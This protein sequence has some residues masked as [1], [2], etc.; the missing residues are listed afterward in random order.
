MHLVETAD[1]P[2][3]I[4]CAGNCPAVGGSSAPPLDDWQQY[5]SNAHR[6]TERAIHLCHV[7]GRRRARPR[8]IERSAARFFEVSALAECIG[9][10]Q[11]NEERLDAASRLQ[12]RGQGICPA[13]ATVMRVPLLFVL[14]S[15]TTADARIGETPIQFA[16]RYG[17]P[18]DTNLTAIVDKS[19]P[20]LEGA[21]HHTYEYQGWKI[22][23]AFLQ[24]DGP[25]VRMAFQKTSAAVSGIVIRED[26]LQAIASANMPAG[27][28]WKPIAYDNPNSPNKGIAKAFEGL[29][30]GAA[31]Q[32]MWQRSDGAILAVQSNVIVR[33]ELPAA[34]Q[35]EEQLKR[36]KEEKARASVPQF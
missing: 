22:R 12:Q 29:I 36:I 24:L 19:S 8:R 28:T 26:E 16:D 35:H 31:G 21:V 27:M 13:L 32:K 17:R 6:A 23:A 7:P 2:G 11:H 14:L 18:R 5:I 20:L 4:K 15:L 9:I 1:F 33:L 34:R 25:C 3:T 30:A 10:A